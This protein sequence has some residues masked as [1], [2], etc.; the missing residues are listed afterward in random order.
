MVDRDG[1]HSGWLIKVFSKEVPLSISWERK[2]GIRC[3]EAKSRSSV[4]M[5]MMFG[6]VVDACAC[7]VLSEDSA[8]SEPEQPTAR[9][10]AKHAKIPKS[11]HLL[12]F[13]AVPGPLPAPQS[14]RRS[15]SRLPLRSFGAT[16]SISSE[17]PRRNPVL[18]SENPVSNP[19]R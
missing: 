7:W 17:Y 3:T 11:I 15:G 12:V 9:K 1:Q 14:L 8:A 19:A 10:V 5:K 13:L 2:V 18:V 16:A 6:R 4:R